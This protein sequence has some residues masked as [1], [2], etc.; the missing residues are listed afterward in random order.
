MKAQAIP[1]LVLVAIV[2]MVVLVGSP[3]SGQVASTELIGTVTDTSGARLPGV[4]VNASQVG[5]GVTR[6]AVSDAQGRYTFTQ[7][8]VGR[9]SFEFT[10]SGFTTV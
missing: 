10:L 4:T 7:L 8:P 1:F 6:S 5:T 2:S 3:A 9:W